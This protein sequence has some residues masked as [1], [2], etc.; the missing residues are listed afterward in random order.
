MVTIKPYK[1]SGRNVKT[2]FVYTYET[3]QTKIKEEKKK[4]VNPYNDSFSLLF[5]LSTPSPSL[6]GKN[7]LSH[8]ITKLYIQTPF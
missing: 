5:C 8:F 3:K 6:Q 7:K 2:I 4:G 1:R